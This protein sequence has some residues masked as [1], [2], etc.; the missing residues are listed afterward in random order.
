[1]V[2]VIACTLNAVRAAEDRSPEQRLAA[3]GL[4]LPVVPASV[5]N[6][7]PAVRSGN[8]VFL[9]G[10]VARGAGGKILAGKV[11]RDCTE[12][13]AAEAA[14][15]CAL[16]LLAARKAEKSDLAKVKRIVRVGGFVNC[17]AGFTAP[18]KVINGDSDL[19]VAVFGDRGRHA[20]TSVRVAALPGD[21]PVEIEL[22]V[23]VAD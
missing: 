5:A 11:G 22:I 18:P 10:Q 23:E 2:L 8:L 3:L 16:Q 7:V 4:T 6:Y 17:T 20:R 13:Q 15:T 1:M 9:A 14:R 19:L 21:A 12:A